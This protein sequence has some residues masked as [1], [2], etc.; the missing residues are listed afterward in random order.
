MPFLKPIRI[1]PILG[2]DLATTLAPIVFEDSRGR[3]WTVPKGF[4]FDGASVPR[5][6]RWLT[7][8]KL[9][10]IAAAAI[11]DELYRSGRVPKREADRV[12]R[13][14]LADLGVSWLERWLMW[15]GVAVGGWFSW[16]RHRQR[17]PS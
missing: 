1:Q 6:L 12:F 10:T 11:H 3:R 8:S 15:A 5:P 2:E 14:A 13:E 9:K 4:R 16:Y 7:P 17:T